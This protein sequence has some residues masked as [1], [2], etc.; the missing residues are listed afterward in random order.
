MVRRLAVMAPLLV[1]GFT[2]GTCGAAKA[3]LPP[4]V[5]FAPVTVQGLLHPATASY[6][7]LLRGVA[8]AHAHRQLAPMA[9]LKFRVVDKTPSTKPLSLRL[10]TDAKVIPIAV[11]SDGMFVLPTPEEA[12]AHEGELVANR[13]SGDLLID[14]IVSTPGY[15]PEVARMGDRRLWCQVVYA[16][17]KD[18]LPPRVQELIS[19]GQG[20][21]TNSRIKIYSVAR[22]D[23]LK[24]A[25]LSEG[26]R[27]LSLTINPQT[28]GFSVPM[29]DPS[30]SNEALLRITYSRT[31]P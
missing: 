28:N 27:Q 3:Q 21:C 8:A 13:P 25:E 26:S 23:V 10:E 18:G 31:E 5:S 17:D 19:G 7:K 12:G 29:H 11:D 1:A 9:T 24:T 16:I 14:P 20:P 6:A 22:G 2:A 4:P 30:W 15:P